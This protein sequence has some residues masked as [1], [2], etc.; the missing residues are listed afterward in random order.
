M[1]RKPLSEEERIRRRRESNQKRHAKYRSSGNGTT[2]TISL[3]KDDN[4]H[5]QQILDS[6]S[7]SFPQFI[8]AIISGELKV[9]RSD[10]KQA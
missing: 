9:I 8:R 6:F 7:L 1:G 10:D 2:K 3:T 4:E 5:L